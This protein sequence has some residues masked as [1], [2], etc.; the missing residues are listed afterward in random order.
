M[1][2]VNHAASWQ[3]AAGTTFNLSLTGWTAPQHPRLNFTLI[4]TGMNVVP[5]GTNV[6]MRNGVKSDASVQRLR[7]LRD[8]FTRLLQQLART[9]QHAEE[10]R[11]LVASAC[12]QFGGVGK[13]AAGFPSSLTGTSLR[14]F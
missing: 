4:S 14:K 5:A 6:A 10:T 9:R 12:E 7:E 13:F 8:R 3:V 2:A 11:R 1:A